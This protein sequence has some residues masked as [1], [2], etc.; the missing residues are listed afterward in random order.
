MSRWDKI[1]VGEGEAESS[2]LGIELFL[3][4]HAAVPPSW[5]ISSITRISIIIFFIL[6]EGHFIIL[7]RQFKYFFDLYLASYDSRISSPRGG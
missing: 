4:F 2:R 5:N 7:T 6:K 3:R 1:R